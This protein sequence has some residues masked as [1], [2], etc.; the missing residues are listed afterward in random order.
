MKYNY[1]V[2]LK[3]NSHTTRGESNY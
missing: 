2:L 1:G 3:A